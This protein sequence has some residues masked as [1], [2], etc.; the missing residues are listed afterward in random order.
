MTNDI[1]AFAN[2][3]PLFR[4][5]EN[6]ATYSALTRE[7]QIQYDDSFN[8]YLAYIGQVQYNL[9]K[10]GVNLLAKTMPK[11]SFRHHFFQ[12]FNSGG[13]D[14]IFFGKM[15]LQYFEH[16]DGTIIVSLFCVNIC[17]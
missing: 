6:I 17:Q 11:S 3:E 16:L 9:R 15:Q 7:Q 1:E 5:L 2:E 8:N 10:G 4:R 12:F 14:T 13:K